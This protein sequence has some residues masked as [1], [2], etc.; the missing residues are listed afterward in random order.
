MW[1]WLTLDKATKSGEGEFE[2]IFLC[3]RCPLGAS[4]HWDTEDM[5]F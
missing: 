4:V 1:N 5:D 2:N 3:A